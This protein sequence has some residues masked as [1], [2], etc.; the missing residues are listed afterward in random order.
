MIKW[1]Y[2]KYAITFTIVVYYLTMVG[3]GT[4]QVFSQLDAITGPGVSAYGTL[5]LLPAAAVALLKWRVEK[6]NAE[7][8]K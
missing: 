2:E 5:M 8:D 7:S 6:D 3:Y 4:Y 1:M